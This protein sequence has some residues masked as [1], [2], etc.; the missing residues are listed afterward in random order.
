MATFFP[1]QVMYFPIASSILLKGRF[2]AWLP[3]EGESHAPVPSW[4]RVRKLDN[5]HLCPEGSALIGDALLTDMTTLFD[6]APASPQWAQGAWTTD[7]DFND[8][9]GACPNDH[10]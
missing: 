10:P 1:G 9:P 5:V 4:T 6:L 8:P 3:P 2:S 7:P